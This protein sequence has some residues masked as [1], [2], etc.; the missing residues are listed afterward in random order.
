MKKLLCLLLVAVMALTFAACGDKDGDTTTTTVAGETTTAA[1]VAVTT[2][3]PLKVD[4]NLVATIK[5][6][7]LVDS[8]GTTIVKVEAN[9]KFVDSDGKTVAE[10]KNGKVLDANGKTIFTVK[11]DGSLVGADGQEITTEAP[12][13]V[14][15]VVDNPSGGDSD[16][17]TVKSGDDTP[18]PPPAGKTNAE[19]VAAYNAAI[20]KAFDARVG[21]EKTRSTDNEKL[22]ANVMVKPFKSLVYKFMGIGSANAYTESV[23]KGAWN[24]EDAN[25]HYLRKS[26]ITTSDITGAKYETSGANTVITLNI[27]DGKSTGGKDGATNNSPVDKCG[28]CV[29]DKDKG[30]YDHKTGAVIYDAIDDTFGSAKIS[31]SY[32]GAVAKIVIDANGNLVSFNVDYSISCVIEFAGT[33]TATGN[34]HIAYKNF[35][36]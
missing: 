27:K 26:T 34:T 23:A 17:T 30:Y 29:G 21:F 14:A 8:N 4:G 18:T 35:K 19:I 16:T 1:P 13:T 7:V 20:N 33:S 28:I 31:E 25:K 5:D 15:P 32:S 10:V 2:A 12:T 6:G 9:Q 36:W 3:E 22:D 24:E 11:D